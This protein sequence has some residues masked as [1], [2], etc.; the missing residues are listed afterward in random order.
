MQQLHLKLQPHPSSPVYIF[1]LKK[2]Y[3]KNITKFEY[4]YEYKY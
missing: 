1:S 3:L 4:K 2:Y